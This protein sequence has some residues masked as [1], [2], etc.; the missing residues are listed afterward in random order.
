MYTK[1]E[2]VE[3]GNSKL[4]PPELLPT[5]YSY[6]DN[7]L[8]P[9]FDKY[10]HIDDLSQLA[11]I[12]RKL[13]MDNICLKSNM[14]ILDREQVDMEELRFQ[15]SSSNVVRKLSKESDNKRRRNRRNADEIN[16]LYKC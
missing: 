15:A 14:N 3:S 16:R 8:C 13:Y 4:I 9:D 12:A 2:A 6:R 1:R 11:I 10:M 5:F 7:M